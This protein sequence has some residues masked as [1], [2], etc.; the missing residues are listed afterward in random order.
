MRFRL[1]STAFTTL[2]LGT[3]TF[4]GPIEST[5]QRRNTNFVS[6]N[7]IKQGLLDAHNDYRRVHGVPEL[8]WDPSLASFAEDNT[9]NCDGEHTS[10][11]KLN[12]GGLVRGESLIALNSGSEPTPEL[13]GR[14]ARGWY[15]T[16]VGNYD[17]TNPDVKKY[18]EYD[19]AGDMEH[20][21]GHMVQVLWK[22]TTKVGCAAR[23]CKGENNDLLL[24]CNYN[25]AGGIRTANS[26]LMKEYHRK[27]ILPVK[28]GF[29]A[30][31]PVPIKEFLNNYL[32][33]NLKPMQQTK[34]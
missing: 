11:A 24:K 29:E 25:P 14:L 6:V 20:Q 18:A 2:L 26:E 4:A 15:L 28:A 31:K 19:A 17:F 30:P 7:Q 13:L 5:L 12:E 10:R 27:N 1:I 32:F 16:E 23:K 22:A 9:P 21:T 34:P 8:I 3:P 33:K